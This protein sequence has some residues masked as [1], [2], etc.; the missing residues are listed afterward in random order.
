MKLNLSINLKQFPKDGKLL[1][2]FDI[3][4]SLPRR[5]L[6]SAVKAVNSR[7]VAVS[8]FIF[9]QYADSDAMRHLIVRMADGSERKYFEFEAN[10]IEIIFMEIIKAADA[11]ILTAMQ[12]EKCNEHASASGTVDTA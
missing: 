6:L 7:G 3:G 11:C 5:K 4:H 8:G 10:T 9:H 12:N 2:L 1:S